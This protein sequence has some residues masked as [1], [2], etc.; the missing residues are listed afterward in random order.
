MLEPNYWSN[1]S[2]IPSQP[3]SCVV[4]ISESCERD[5]ASS[6]C[7]DHAGSDGRANSISGRGCSRSQTDRVSADMDCMTAEIDRMSAVRV[8]E[9]GGGLVGVRNRRVGSRSCMQHSRS[10]GDHDRCNCGRHIR[11]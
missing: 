10:V 9:C 6:D 3:S 8:D 2:R 4:M 7:E 5:E 1:F 11:S